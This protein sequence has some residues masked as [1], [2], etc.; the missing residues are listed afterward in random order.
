MF[1]RINESRNNFKIF[2]RKNFGEIKRTTKFRRNIA[3]FILFKNFCSTTQTVCFNLF[4]VILTLKT[5][6][7]A[8]FIVVGFKILLKF[9]NILLEKMLIESCKLNEGKTPLKHRKT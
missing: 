6:A 7:E 3:G 9:K 1:R 8:F 5:P 4:L 2:F